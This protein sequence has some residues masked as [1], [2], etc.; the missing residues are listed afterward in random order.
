M[1]KLFI[2]AGLTMLSTVCIKAQTADPELEYVKKAYSKEKKMIVDEYMNL[3]VQEGAK[4]WPVY[5]AYESSREK[6]AVQRVK[7]INEYLNS[8]DKLTPEVAD[9]LAS[10]VLANN[11]SLEKLNFDTYGKMKKAIGAIKAAK[12]L[13]METYLQTTWKRYVQNNIPLIGELDKTEQ[14]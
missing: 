13:Q 5:G 7:L 10:Q 8:A 4:F 12:F 3:D 1:R 9:K 14:H 2:L 6:L 11:I